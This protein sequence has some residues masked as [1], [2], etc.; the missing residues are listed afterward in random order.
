MTRIAAPLRLVGFGEPEPS[1][2]RY[3]GFRDVK[4]GVISLVGLPDETLRH[5]YLLAVRAPAFRR[6]LRSAH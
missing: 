5:N 1:H 2:D 3:E 4:D 6:Q